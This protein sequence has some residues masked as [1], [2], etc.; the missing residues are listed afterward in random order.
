[1]LACNVQLITRIVFS[2]TS[3]VN[4]VLAKTYEP[5]N[6]SYYE[7]KPRASVMVRLCS[8]HVLFQAWMVK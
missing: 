5:G 4:G 8:I 7:A 1:M 3:D 6:G 2:L